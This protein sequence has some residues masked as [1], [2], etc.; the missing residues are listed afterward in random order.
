MKIKI[1]NCCRITK[2]TSSCKRK[3]GKIFNLPRRFSKKKCIN[4]PVRGFT[5]SSSCAPYKFCK[6]RKISQKP[7]MMILARQSPTLI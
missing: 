6:K 2:N 4:G 1:E 3:D 5:M 7:P